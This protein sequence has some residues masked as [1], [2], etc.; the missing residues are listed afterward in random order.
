MAEQQGQVLQERELD[1]DESDPEAR[2][3]GDRGGVGAHPL[4]L[5][6][7]E[8]EEERAQREDRQEDPQEGPLHG[9]RQA[10]RLRPCEEEGPVVE[11]GVDPGLRLG[12]VVGE[13]RPA[14]EERRV[15]LVDVPSGDDDGLHAGPGGHAGG[16]VLGPG[17]LLEHEDHLWRVLAIALARLQES[18]HALPGL[19]DTEKRHRVRHEA[20]RVHVPAED[21]ELPVGRELV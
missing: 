10:P 19:F 1:R 20:R 6:L 3:V 5:R 8:G 18:R 2:E 12:H 9:P 15:G 4:A 21:E 14:R 17:P 13:A 7:A 16:L 11:D